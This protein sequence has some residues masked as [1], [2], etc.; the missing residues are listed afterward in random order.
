MHY[1]LVSQRRLRDF[2]LEG[3]DI[4]GRSYYEVFPNVP[5]RWK[6]LH[7][8]C[9]AGAMER[10]EEDRFIRP[11]GRE[12]WLRWEICPWRDQQGEI[13]AMMI[14]S[15]VITD[16]KLAQE[17]LRQS[18]AE[19]RRLLAFHEAVTTNMGEG[20]YA[21]DTQGLVT[22]MNPAAEMSSA[23]GRQLVESAPWERFA[24]WAIVSG[25]ARLSKDTVSAGRRDHASETHQ[26]ASGARRGRARPWMGVATPWRNEE[27]P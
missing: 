25:C 13:G 18:E 22:Y 11:D 27:R 4:I 5:Q 2:G 17:A 12:V 24:A 7:R 14:F 8:R 26:D 6:E 23:G 10:C 1:L 3:Q 9:L 19:S 20:L 21:V 16:R 15:E